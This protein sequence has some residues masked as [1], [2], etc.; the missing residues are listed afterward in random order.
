MHTLADLLA[1]V[2]QQPAAAEAR[3]PPAAPVGPA[4]S[5]G[6][7]PFL[8]AAERFARLILGRPDPAA[9]GGRC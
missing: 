1:S 2:Q 4:A 9:R 3:T 5:P 6:P 8:E 7:V